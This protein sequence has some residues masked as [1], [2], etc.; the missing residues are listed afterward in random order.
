MTLALCNDD[1]TK[2]QS[3]SGTIVERFS[4][5]DC[6]ALEIVVHT[7]KLPKSTSVD[8]EITLDLT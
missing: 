7:T 2:K 4:R 6:I 3:I 1:I 8:F 5:M